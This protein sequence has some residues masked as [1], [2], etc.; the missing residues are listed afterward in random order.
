MKRRIPGS[1]SIGYLSSMSAVM[2]ATRSDEPP[3]LDALPAV[4]LP[5]LRDGLA[6][7]HLVGTGEHIVGIHRD[8]R[9][10]LVANERLHLAVDGAPL[11]LVELGTGLHQELVELFVVPMG[12]VPRRAPGI[13]EAEHPVFGRPPAPKSHAEGLL[14]PHIGPVAV[15]CLTHHLDLDA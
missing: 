8:D 2:Q 11:A 10:A 3:A 9:A 7:R 6:A 1:S 15:I 4:D 14:G 13:D 12:V 5:A